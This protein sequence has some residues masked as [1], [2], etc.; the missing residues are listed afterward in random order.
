[1]FSIFYNESVVHTA[2]VR[3]TCT[4]FNLTGVQKG[5]YR[6][7]AGD[8]GVENET[9]GGEVENEKRY[10]TTGIKRYRCQPHPGLQG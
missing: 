3:P 9:W 1:M 10:R 8:G 4:H 7:R 6:M 5:K 2:G